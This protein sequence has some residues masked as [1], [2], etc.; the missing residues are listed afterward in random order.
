[1]EARGAEALTPPVGQDSLAVFGLEE[2]TFKRIRFQFG[3]RLERNAYSPD[4]LTNRSFTGLSGSTG[5][6]VPTWKNG[7]LVVNYMHSYRAPALEE[8]Y[9]KGPHPG[10]LAFEIG[11]AN[12]Q[13]ERSDGVELSLRHQG[14]RFRLET[15]VFD[16]QMHDFVYFQPTG[17]VRDNLPVYYYRQNNARFLGAEARAQFLL[18]RSLWLS[19]GVDYVDANLTGRGMN[20]PRIPPGRGRVG[21]DW[22]WKGLNLRPELVLANK[23]WQLAPNETATPG[24]A[25]VNMNA[26]YTRTTQHVMHTFSVNTFN[27]GDRLYYNHLNF[28]KSFAPEIG[29]GVR[30]GY[31]LQWF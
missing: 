30:V 10:N 29:R 7:A 2:L 22:F 27:L 26:S 18:A 1:Y 6:Y 4:G 20:L 15:N 5:A 31:T 11:N 13:R 3:A 21:L 9:N 24:Y 14:N 12:L 25:L 17:E 28:L 23:Q 16:Y 8:L 19:T